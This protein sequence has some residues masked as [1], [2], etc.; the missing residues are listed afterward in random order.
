MGKCIDKR[1]N[2]LGGKRLIE[3]YCGDEGTGLEETIE[4]WKKTSLTTVRKVYTESLSESK[5]EL[6][7]DDEEK[8]GEEY[9]NLSI[10]G[11]GTTVP[12][13]LQCNTNSPCT[14]ETGEYSP[15][16]PAIKMP[17][18]ILTANEV[19]GL[20]GL[21]EKL[22]TPPTAAQLPRAK[23]CIEA[24]C[25]Y[26]FTTGDTTTLSTILPCVDSCTSLKSRPTSEPGAP[27]EALW[28]ADN[29]FHATVTA[30]KWLTQR[31]LSLIHI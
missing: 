19:A 29:P 15:I 9:R 27:Y 8:L 2:E 25:P 23:A 21:T 3:L 17:E 28:T 26:K 30:A 20:L 13:E 10:D 16:H 14:D 6:E 5:L 7:P 18:N 24:K 12:S 31:P 11:T 22:S 1:L 4:A